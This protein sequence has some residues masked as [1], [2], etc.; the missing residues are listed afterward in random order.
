VNDLLRG[1]GL[2][3]L[4]GSAAVRKAVADRAGRAVAV[5]E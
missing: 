3:R 2:E 4:I 5:E 1:A